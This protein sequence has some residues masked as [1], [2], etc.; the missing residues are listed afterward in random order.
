ML[1]YH[2]KKNEKIPALLCLKK[3][4]KKDVVNFKKSIHTYVNI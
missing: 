2:I 4:A 1:D 3:I